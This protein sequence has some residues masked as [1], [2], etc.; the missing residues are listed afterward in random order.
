MEK[1]KQILLSSLIVALAL[2]TAWAIRGK[3][4]HEQG[5]AWAGAVGAMS[6]VMVAK[7][8]DWY[9][10]IFKIA[11]ASGVGWGLSGMISYGQIVGYGRA[12]DFG[13]AYYGLLMLFV[14]GVLYGFLGGGLV[15]LALADTK[16]FKVKWGSLMAEMVALA[17]LSYGLLI[18][19]LEWLMTPPRS[20]LWAAC[21]GGSLALAWYAIRNQQ[22]G[23]LNVAVWSALGAGF[24]FAFG[25]FLQV[26]G[27]GSALKINYWNVME[28]SIGFFGGFGMAYGTFISTWAVT[29]TKVSRVSNF[30]PILFLVVFIPFVLWDQSFASE[31]LKF[32]IELGGSVNTIL[33]F[34]S[35]ALISILIC[36]GIFFVF[37]YRLSY[38]ATDVRNIFVLYLG[39]Y[40]FLSFLLTGIYVHPIEQY[41]YIVNII[42]VLLL[43]RSVTSGFIMREQ[44]PGEWLILSMFSILVIAA[45]ALI[46][47]TSHNGI[48]GSNV[49][50][51]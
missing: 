20:E 19:Q 32:I 3:F 26:L 13:N 37:Y 48:H 24:G 30:V 31:K 44:S 10:Q 34:Q 36:L 7:R 28:Y 45:F 40:T 5:A 1:R 17:L 38:T 49:R 51:E 23:V 9:N 22:R 2:G 39:L 33:F 14:I 29:E 46:A 4:G 11:L 6:L 18:N 50:F 16:T 35:A 41:L 25:N 15:G 47:I 27:A 8:Q 43:V 12:D 42:V 21:L